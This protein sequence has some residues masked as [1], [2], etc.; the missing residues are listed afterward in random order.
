MAVQLSHIVDGQLAA[1]TTTL[2]T[3]PANKVVVVMSILATN[4]NTSNSRKVNFYFKSTGASRHITPVDRKLEPGQTM[5]YE[6]RVAMSES[7]DIEGSGEVAN[8]ID[9]WITGFIQDV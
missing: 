9:Y 7:F 5:I 8:E 4:R 6:M 3:V 2:Y 1:T